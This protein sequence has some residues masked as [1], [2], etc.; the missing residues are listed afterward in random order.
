METGIHM[1]V[2]GMVQGVGFR[3]FVFHRATRLTLTGFVQNLPN[4]D[5]E[6]EAEG[7]RSALEALIAEVKIGP[8]AARVSD[9]SLHWEQA[10]G[11]F[12]TFEIR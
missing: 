10:K 2:K 4:G 9:I 8:Q 12:T 1:I 11:L 5:V 7:E 3:Y 6:I